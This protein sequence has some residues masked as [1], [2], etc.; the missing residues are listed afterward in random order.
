MKA[1]LSSVSPLCGV[2]QAASA[3]AVTDQKSLG[4]RVIDTVEGRSQASLLIRKMYSWRGYPGTHKL[5]D[6]ANRITLIAS[7]GGDVIG[8]LTLGIDSPIGIMADEIFKEEV[9]SVRM[10]PG[11]RVCE[12]TKLAFDNG[13]RKSQLASLFHLSVIYARDLYH[14]THIFIEINPRHRRFY[15]AMLGFKRLGELKTNPRV[16]APAYLLVVELTYVSEQIEKYGGQGSAMS[17]SV[18]SFY[19]FFYSPRE[20]RRIIPG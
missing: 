18:R 9:D 5:T 1:F 10:I 19:P 2:V 11:A 20:E 3:S 6:D 4:F 16:D 13:G 7:E 15:E 12:I 17:T 14:C 8:T